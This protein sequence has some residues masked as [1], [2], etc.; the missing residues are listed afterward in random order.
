MLVAQGY[1]FS[2][3]VAFISALAEILVVILAA[4]PYSPGE[5]FLELIICTY[6]SIGILSLKVIV[7]VSL[8]F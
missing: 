5:I 4:I 7:L 2:A 8:V 1:F 3:S 6:I